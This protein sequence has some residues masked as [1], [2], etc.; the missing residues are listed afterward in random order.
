[1]N[2][3]KAMPANGNRLRAM[4]TSPPAGVVEHP[5]AGSLRIVR[6]GDLDE[7][8]RGTEEHGE[9]DAGDGGCLRRADRLARRR[10]RP[11]FTGAR[12]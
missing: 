4:T 8:Q 1:M 5:V 6:D 10:D 7:D 9:H 12:V 2:H 11:G 3:R